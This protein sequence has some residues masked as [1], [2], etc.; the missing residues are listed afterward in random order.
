MRHIALVAGL[1]TTMLLPHP[2]AQAT[3]FGEQGNIGFSVLVGEDDP[4][5]YNTDIHLIRPDGSGLRR[6]TDSGFGENN[7]YFSPDGRNLV[8]YRDSDGVVLRRRVSGGPERIL[9]RQK[10]TPT[11]FWKPFSV[12]W[13]PDGTKLVMQWQAYDRQNDVWAETAIVVMDAEGGNRKTIVS[14]TP[15]VTYWQPRWSPDGRH[16]LFARPG[17]DGTVSDIMIVEADG[18]EPRV[19]PTDTVF[20][21][22]PTWTPDGRILYVT[23]SC[24]A[25]SRCSEVRTMDL[26]GSDVQTLLTMP[27]LAGDGYPDAVHE[28]VMAPDGS[29]IILTVV[30]TSSNPLMYA[31]WELWNFDLQNSSARRL[32]EDHE[33]VSDWQPG[34]TLRGTPGDDLLVG[35]PGPDLICGL[36]GDDLVKGRGGNDV[37]FGH[38]G[39]DRVVGGAGSDIL[40]GNSGRD[41]C[42]SDGED[43]SDVC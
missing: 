21:L 10:V 40:V 14:P 15:G 29:S 12:N 25:H 37:L 42:D 11:H 34:C 26:D 31:P 20:D 39:S 3:F 2:A 22:V 38:G 32:V 9:A 24:A 35:T 4:A 43:Y 36:G 28:A 16:I 17:L 23:R 7:P 1:V 33:G 13:S 30:S 6:I 27:D 41:R 8:Y 5:I 18:G 19:V